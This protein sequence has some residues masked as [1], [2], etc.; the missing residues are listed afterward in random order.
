MKRF[1][2]SK[3]VLVKFFA[4]GISTLS[5]IGCSVG[6]AP[7][8]TTQ[9]KV[10]NGQSADSSDLNAVGALAFKTS[11]GKWS[12]FCT[13]TLVG[14]TR[15]T[16]LSAR[17]C[18]PTIDK[19]KKDNKGV[20]FNVGPD[21]TKPKASYSVSGYE[22]APKI[23]N[24]GLL[25][26]SSDIAVVY[27]EKKIRDVTPLRWFPLTS[28]LEGKSFQLVG[29]GIRNSA[30]ESGLRMKGEARLATTRGGL[31]FELLFGDFET[32]YKDWYVGDL[33]QEDSDKGRAIA[34]SY[35]DQYALQPNYEALLLP[36]KV[37][38]KGKTLKGSVLCFGDSGGPLLKKIG[39]SYLVFGVAS[40]SESS[41]K[42]ICGYG[43]SYAAIYGKVIPFLFKAL[44]PRK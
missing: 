13:A 33:G 20:F 10:I 26:V 44:Y 39:H 27:L 1:H 6:D 15:K 18:M 35:W 22:L 31:W 30:G 2:Y 8:G 12:S 34:K 25:G 29:Y 28:F 36:Y 23:G 17:H 11:T 21:V 43:T 38:P 14:F 42:Y 7:L 19:L 40:A 4:I 9:Q 5:L 32:F 37:G 3:S 24:G 41:A 16:L